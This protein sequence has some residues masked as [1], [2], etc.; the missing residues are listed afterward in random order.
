MTPDL[1]VGL[2]AFTFVTVITP[3]PNNLML[4][5]SGANYGVRRSLPHMAGVALGFPGMVL[6]VGVGVSRVFDHFPLLGDV[7]LVVSGVYM[8]WLAWKIAHAAPP[9][10]STESAGRPL[11]FLQAAA[12]QWVNPKA[13]SMA[14]ASI[15]LYAASR[16]L[17]AI[18]WIVAAYVLSGIVSTTT[19]AVLGRQLRRFLSNPRR[20]RV[21]NWTMAVLL[22][23]SLIPAL[24]A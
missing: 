16:E 24:V 8:L 18:L 3:G 5:A 23:A 13:W 20:L 7:L 17:P 15:A 1:L 12:F 2:A 14:L 22:V 9:A 10:R 19:W 21:F 11:T 6:L 4:L